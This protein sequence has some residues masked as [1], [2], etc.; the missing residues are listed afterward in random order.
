MIE[1]LLG[2]QNKNKNSNSTALGL[3]RPDLLLIFVEND[4]C[5]FHKFQNC[6]FAFFEPRS[7]GNHKKQFFFGSGLWYD[8]NLAFDNNFDAKFDHFDLPWPARHG[9]IRV[10][11]DV[12][13]G[14]HKKLLGYN[15]WQFCFQLLILMC[16]GTFKCVLGLKRLDQ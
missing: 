2:H 7:Y 8:P 15:C 11:P 9:L 10:Y 16:P 13:L 5:N 1:G 4:P 14:M 12:G 6:D 3:I